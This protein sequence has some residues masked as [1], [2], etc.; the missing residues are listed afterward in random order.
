MP[1]VPQEFTDG[2]LAAAGHAV[3]LGCAV[4]LIILAAVVGS[5]V[6]GKLTR[7]DSPRDKQGREVYRNRESNF[8][9]GNDFM[10]RENYRNWR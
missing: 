2:V 1:T 7:V 5:R 3:I 6:V 10:G 9:S 8:T 4:A